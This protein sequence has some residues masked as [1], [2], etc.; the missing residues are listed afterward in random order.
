MT[1]HT[2]LTNQG[3]E[4]IAYTTQT[5][6]GQSVTVAR[7]L[8][9]DSTP[10]KDP[11]RTAT[12]ITFEVL[13]V[14]SYEYLKSPTESQGEFRV[15]ATHLA[16][17]WLHNNQAFLRYHLGRTDRQPEIN[18]GRYSLPVFIA[19]EWKPAEPLTPHVFQC[20]CRQC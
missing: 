7:L 12:K 9:Q 15:K 2:R 1:I 6:D 17:E 3:R 20:A 5:D 19:D 8:F 4:T 16:G 13:G 11:R 14:C 10:G 18:F